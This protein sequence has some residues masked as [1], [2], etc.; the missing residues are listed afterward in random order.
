M[1]SFFLSFF[2]LI[3]L[4]NQRD[5]LWLALR[6]YHWIRCRLPAPSC[7]GG[8]PCQREEEIRHRVCTCIR[9]QSLMTP[10]LKKL[11]LESPLRIWGHYWLSAS[12]A[13]FACVVFRSVL[14]RV[15]LYHIFS[16]HRRRR[17]RRGRG[18][19]KNGNFE[20]SEAGRMVIIQFVTD[21]DICAESSLFVSTQA[22]TEVIY[23][24]R[25]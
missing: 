21:V 19:E 17:R 18:R 20:S 9:H 1:F 3:V 2:F 6:F 7:G 13:G 23:L 5:L 12:G 25:G 10:V 14:P 16:L 4:T 24:W 11:R 15:C 22:E 8:G